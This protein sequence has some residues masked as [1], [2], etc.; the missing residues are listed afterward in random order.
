[1][2]YYSKNYPVIIKPIINLLGMSR[3]F[4]IN[5]DEFLG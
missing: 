3:G 5:I 4:K 1:M 2:A